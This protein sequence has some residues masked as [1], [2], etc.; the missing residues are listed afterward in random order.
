[1]PCNK[2][3]FWDVENVENETAYCKKIRRMRVKTKAG[4]RGNP[5]FGYRHVQL[6]THAS[7]VCP[8]YR[9]DTEVERA[10]AL[11]GC[12]AARVQA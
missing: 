4:P 3:A 7:N 9:K 5:T 6:L 2:C 10:A 12:G 1:M 8:D 11:A